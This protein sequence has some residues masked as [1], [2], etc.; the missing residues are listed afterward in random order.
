MM[1]WEKIWE[2]ADV[3]TTVHELLERTRVCRGIALDVCNE[4]MTFPEFHER[5]DRFAA[6]LQAQGY[7]RKDIIIVSMKASA[8]LFCMIAAALKAG[9]IL[10]VTEDEVA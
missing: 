9:V 6:W 7:G 1:D 5:S 10:T 8:N 2:K 4:T 3:H